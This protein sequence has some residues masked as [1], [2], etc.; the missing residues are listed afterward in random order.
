MGKWEL[1]FNRRRVSAQRDENAL[2]K[3]GGSGRTVPGCL[4][5][6]ASA[7]KNG[8]DAKCYI[9]LATVAKT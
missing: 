7:P 5:P 3:D 1:L 9:R 4:G 6:L 2:K 8:S